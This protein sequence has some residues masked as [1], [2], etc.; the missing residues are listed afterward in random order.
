MLS[1]HIF[2]PISFNRN[3]CSLNKTIRNYS[4][5]TDILNKV[6]KVMSSA[7]SNAS[8]KV[9]YALEKY[10]ND[11]ED[12]EVKNKINS[13]TPSEKQAGLKE[14]IKKVYW[15]TGTSIAI[16][17][18]I[19]AIIYTL[20]PFI[21]INHPITVFCS[22][23]GMILLSSHML[24]RTKS[25]ICIDEKLKTCVAIHSPWKNIWTWS[26]IG[27]TGLAMTWPISVL[28]A[29]SPAFIPSFIL[30]SGL[31]FWG[32]NYYVN[33]TKDEISVISATLH[34]SMAGFMGMGLVTFLC[35][36]FFPGF[37][38][39]WFMTDAYIGI[40]FFSMLTAF[41]THNAIMKYNE[42][43]L[44]DIQ[45]STDLFI[46]F[47]KIFLEFLRNMLRIIAQTLSKKSDK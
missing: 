2:K 42:G 13:L 30:M 45:V 21:I 15:N 38:E 44:D 19:P 28:Y 29:I 5:H 17:T 3:I 14:F 8:N 36:P 1:R 39:L 46:K 24:R 9:S 26:L 18:S 43:K 34:S 4:S 27:S 33:K 11:K 41:D 16:S 22:S 7:V 35:Y 6:G 32:A 23:V 10:E 12:S 37:S 40:M 47:M 31:S 25:Q 20:E